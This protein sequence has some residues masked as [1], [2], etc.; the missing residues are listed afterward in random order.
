MRK[1][2]C[3]AGEIVGIPQGPPQGHVLFSQLPSWECLDVAVLALITIHQVTAM[4]TTSKNVLFPGYNHLLTTGTDDP[5][6]AGS[7]V[8]IKVKSHQYQWLAGGYDLEIG[9]VK[10]WLA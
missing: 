7:R 10:K 5:S 4:L 3:P 1:G 6:L 8:I 2:H 9:H